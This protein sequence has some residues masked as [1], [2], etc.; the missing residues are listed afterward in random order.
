[1]RALLSRGIL[2]SDQS[3]SI[4][5]R[6]FRNLLSGCTPRGNC[7]R[8]MN[9]ALNFFFGTNDTTLCPERR[10]RLFAAARIALTSKWYLTASS[11]RARRTSS[12]TGSL[13]M[14]YSPMSSSGVQITGHSHAC[15]RQMNASALVI[16]AFAM[17]TQFQVT[18]KSIPCT[19]AMAMCA[20]S[21]AALRGILPAARILD[22]NSATS[23]VMSSNGRSWST[24]SR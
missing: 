21:V 4:A 12:M 14:T 3:R 13:S 9:Q 20:A 15:S 18:R 5:E 16:A 19:A 10:C 23:G 7:C 22:A 17:C 8:S 1:M 2:P 11:S 24:F 6:F